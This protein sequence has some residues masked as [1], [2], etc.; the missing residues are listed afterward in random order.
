MKPLLNPPFLMWSFSSIVKERKRSLDKI[1]VED[2]FHKR[3][4]QSWSHPLIETLE[5][6]EIH[7]DV[8][9]SIIVDLNPT[10]L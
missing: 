1:H 4:N 2:F 5:E 10:L 6:H 8:S 3:F 9:N 7:S